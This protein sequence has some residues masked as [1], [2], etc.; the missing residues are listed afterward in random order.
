MGARDDL[1]LLLT[2]S[3]GQPVAT[4]RVAVV[5]SVGTGVVNV[6]LGGDTV[7]VPAKRLAGYTPTVD[8]VVVV[9][10]QGAVLVVLDAVS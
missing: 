8:D 3:G 4:L 5:D 2:R 6:R 7:A 9:L 10:Q 1:A